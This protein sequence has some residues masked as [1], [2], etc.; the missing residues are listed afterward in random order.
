MKR[1]VKLLRVAGYGLKLFGVFC[2]VFGAFWCWFLVSGC[3]YAGS[4]LLVNLLRVTSCGLRVVWCLVF[5]I[6][7]FLLLV[8]LLRVTGWNCFSRSECWI[9]TLFDGT[10]LLSNKVL[11]IF[12]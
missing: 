6:W 7:C 10:L 4:W 11:F 8:N 9:V 5:G 3:W 2:L 1:G 12:F